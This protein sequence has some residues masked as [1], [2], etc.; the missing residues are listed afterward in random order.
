MESAANK[1]QL[2]PVI[3]AAAAYTVAGLVAVSLDSPAKGHAILAT[4]I[5]GV[6][7]VILLAR[8]QN[9]TTWLTALTVIVPISIFQVFPDWF[10]ADTLRTI[11][12][13]DNGGIRLGEEIPLAMAGLW[14]LPLLITTLLAKD[15]LWRGAIIAAALF[16]ATE[17]LAPSI[18][19]WEPS[20]GLRQI[21][22]VAVYVIPA[23]AALGAATVYAVRVAG[24]SGWPTRI[25]AAAAVSIF[26]T[27]ALALSAFLIESASFMLSY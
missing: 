6:V 27:G 22:G 1:Q 11:E 4:S 14:V 2:W 20:D 25:T 21:F 13:P 23:E 15:R 7:G 9:R 24:G 19:L 10:L 26:Y 16:F 17:L 5:G 3:A 18:G 8:G 12:F